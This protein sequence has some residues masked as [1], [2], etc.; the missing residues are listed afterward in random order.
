MQDTQKIK[1]IELEYQ[2]ILTEYNAILI[3]IASATIGMGALLYTLTK[4]PEI[5][6]AAFMFTFLILSSEKDN[7]SKELDNK[8]KEII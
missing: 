8:V 3:G 1:K 6:I 4:K 5:S 2:K 7:K